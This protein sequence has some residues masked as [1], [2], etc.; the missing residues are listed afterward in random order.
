MHLIDNCFIIYYQIVHLPLKFADSAVHTVV[1]WIVTALNYAIILVRPYL[2]K[3]N[4]IID[5][6][7]HTVTW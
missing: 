7:T 5:W 2:Y 1:F 3:F 4:P 6:L